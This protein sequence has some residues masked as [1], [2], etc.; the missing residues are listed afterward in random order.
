ME[1]ALAFLMLVAVVVS[2]IGLNLA[3]R[4]SRAAMSAEE[5]KAK[6]DER[7]GYMRAW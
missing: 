6:D 2:G 7:P 3:A 4:R 1:L 5:R